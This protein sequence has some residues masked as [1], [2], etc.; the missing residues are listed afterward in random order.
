MWSWGSLSAVLIQK[1]AAAAFKDGATH[2]EVK[3]LA[4]LGD[5]GAQPGKCIFFNL[6]LQA[7][8][9]IQHKSRRLH[10]DCCMRKNQPGNCHRDLCQAL[11]EP[12][13]HTAMGYFSAMVKTR[14]QRYARVQLPMLY[15]YR[16]VAELYKSHPDHFRDNMLGGSAD[17]VS[18]FWKE[19]ENH[20]AYRHHPVS[21][22]SELRERTIPLVLHGDGVACVAVNRKWSKTAEVFSCKSA[23]ARGSTLQI[24]FLIF[25]LYKTLAAACAA[26]H[27][28]DTV[29]DEMAWSF[30]W[31]ERGQWPDTDRLG[32]PIRYCDGT[33]PLS[34]L[35]GGWCA[36]LFFLIG[37]LDYLNGRLGL[38][39]PGS[40]HPCILC[41]AD[42]GLHAM[43]PW[44]AFC[45]AAAACVA[46]IWTYNAWISAKTS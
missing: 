26:G 41:R 35:A 29:F 6:A 5:H 24:N 8:T 1:T 43:Y 38:E 18:R 15:P 37:D 42:I 31:L 9:K 13:L 44:T 11:K 16:L 2:S 33:V 21:R 36:C 7:T 10:E 25:L 4:K 32:Q 46:S 45:L 39:S 20:P 19:M 3:M 34:E 22:S 27:T 12:T 17:N 28:W 40:L 30:Q 23:L 14:K